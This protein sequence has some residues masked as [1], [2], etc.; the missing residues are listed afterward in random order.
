MA[1]WLIEKGIG[2]ERA[3]LIEN[4][5]VLAA[6]IHWHGEFYA[7][8]RVRARVEKRR[9]GTDR[10]LARTETGSEILLDRL[11]SAASEGSEIDLIITRAPIAEH[12]RSKLAQGRIAVVG[13][14]DVDS[15][16]D[17]LPSS[18]L[19]SRFPTGCWEDVWS[20]A[21]QG[22]VEFA[23]GSLIFSATPAMT[24]IDIDGDGSAREL[25]LAAVPALA[26]SIRKFDLGGSIGV[27]FPTVQHKPD[28][29][30]I[31]NALEAALNEFPHERT[32]MNGFGFVQI[33]A[34][35]EG[36]SL[37]HRIEHSRADAAARF[38]LR[39]AEA[40]EEAG[41][42]LLILHPAVQ[43]RVKEEWLE[44][45]SRRTGREVRIEI[46]PTLALEA[47]FAQAVPL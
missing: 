19:V 21:A 6:K 18:R 15:P 29:R 10:A 33:V 14:G 41:V 22:E 7:N 47:G 38:I 40:V 17:G 26:A 37:L 32:A 2:E 8:Q 44:E 28:R 39:Q 27:D 46:D 20:E 35:S 34:R 25:S 16:F 3:L 9:K 24:L 4:D 12:G 42:L 43:S 30:E 11:P 31:D 45:L 13:D 5:R 36:P 23:G 1:E